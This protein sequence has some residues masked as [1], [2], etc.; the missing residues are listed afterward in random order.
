MLTASNA[1]GKHLKLKYFTDHQMETALAS[2]KHLLA[3]TLRHG[4]DFG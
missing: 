4:S 3:D 1:C 2:P